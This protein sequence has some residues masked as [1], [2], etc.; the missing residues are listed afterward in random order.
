MIHEMSKAAAAR[1]SV[2]RYRARMREAGL[3]LV[4]VWVPDA[5]AR[6]F[7]EEC[8]R[9][10]LAAKRAGRSERDAMKWV[11]TEGWTS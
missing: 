8:R 5:R 4:Q 2:E 3:R 1:K 11:D 7:V 9:Q 6:G 10:S